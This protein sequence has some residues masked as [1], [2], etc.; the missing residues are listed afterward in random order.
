MKSKKSVSQFPTLENDGLSQSVRKPILNQLISAGAIG[1]TLAMASFLTMQDAQA[2]DGVLLS[3]SD[4]FDVTFSGQINRALL[5]ADDGNETTLLHVDNNNSSSRIRFIAQSKN[6]GPLTAGA[7]YEAE[8]PIKNSASIRQEEVNRDDTDAFNARHAEVFF[9]H[10]D[11]GKVWLG[12]GQTATDGVSQRDLSGTMNAGFSY[13]SLVGGGIRFRDAATGELS[14][15]SFGNVSD[16]LDGFSRE[17]RLRYDSPEFSN[18]QLRASLIND[19]AFD[20]SAFYSSRISDYRVV[21]A[22]G[23]GNARQLK[24]SSEYD[25]Q[26]SGSLS[27]RHNTGWNYTFAGGIATAASNG[28]DNTIFFYNKLGY[29]SSLFAGVGGTAL[30]VDWNQTRNEDRNNDVSDTFGVQMAQE[31]DVI[32]TEVYATLRNTSLDRDGSEFDDIWIA[33]VGAR[34]DF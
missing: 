33:M 22:V 3:N 18:W 5:L 4:Q 23:Y 1:S 2:R 8:F 12:Q 13:V 15:T 34:I 14:N 6:E 7:I 9:E 30:S 19:G 21:A 16:N 24:D 32:N 26:L 28:R 10:K 27:L 11:L 31:I 29:R 20:T 25:D 17:T